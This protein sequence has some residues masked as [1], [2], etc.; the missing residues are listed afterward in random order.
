MGVN[1][2]VL[3]SQY[4]DFP[5]NV[6]SINVCVCGTLS[7]RGHLFRPLSKGTQLGG[8]D[9]ED[10]G[11]TCYYVTPFQKHLK[12]RFFSFYLLRAE[13][14]TFWILGDD[15]CV[16]LNISAV[17]KKIGYLSETRDSSC[18]TV[19]PLCLVTKLLLLEG[20][21]GSSQLGRLGLVRSGTSR[22]VKG[23]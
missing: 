19:F 22:P 7:P 5:R 10:T 4:S 3:Y 9:V 16:V 18:H 21:Y 17:F 13:R 14:R 20:L 6:I 23:D 2:S 8:V 11:L 12:T 15:F 1:Y